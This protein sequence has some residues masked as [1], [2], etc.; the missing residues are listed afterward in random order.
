MKKNQQNQIDKKKKAI[1]QQKEKIEEKTKDKKKIPPI[2]PS[3]KQNPL[4]QSSNNPKGKKNNNIT[5]LTT[6]TLTRKKSEQK[7]KIDNKFFEDKNIKKDK[8]R[9]FSH[10][11]ERQVNQINPNIK[12]NK[13]KILQHKNLT[14]RKF[15]TSIK[16]DT[17]KSPNSLRI[18]KQ[19]IFKKDLNE[20][21]QKKN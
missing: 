12:T 1:N 2:T 5:D 13:P 16:S 8:P 4:I 17:S 19:N 6:P 7:Y 11:P 10:S 15:I 18:Q 14:E 20:N 9:L 3:E 21:E